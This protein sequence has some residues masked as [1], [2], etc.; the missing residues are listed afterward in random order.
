MMQT[1]TCTIST[2]YSCG[3]YVQ[4]TIRVADKFLIPQEPTKR[5]PYAR[6][7][8]PTCIMANALALFK[9]ARGPN[10]C[11]QMSLSF[12]GH[13]PSKSAANVSH[14]AKV[15]GAMVCLFASRRS[16]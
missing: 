12:V 11:A 14:A 10:A 8:E 6:S 3:K 15:V 4:D 9:A 1:M 16:T 2:V 13:T 5:H 7:A